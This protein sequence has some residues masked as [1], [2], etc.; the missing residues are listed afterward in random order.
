MIN[1]P[2]AAALAFGLQDEEDREPFLVF[3]VGGGTFDV[4]I[5]E[6]FE[7]VVE[8]RASA[9]DNRL[10]GDDFNEALAAFAKP[11]LDPD[12]RLAA[13]D[14]VKREALLLRAAEAARRL[15]SEADEAVL[16]VV[17]GG[18]ELE[19][20][21]TAADL[22]QACD[23]LIQRLRDPVVRALR[24]CTFEVLELS[25]IVLVGGATRMP[26]VR[27]A[28]TRMFGRFPNTNVHPDHAVALGAAIQAGL[29]PAM[30]RLMKSEFRT[31]ALSPLVSTR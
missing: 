10:G 5:V 21:I 29:L 7:N 12:N 1:E 18:G 14:A 31:S 17:A 2:T 11:R 6:K 3:D 13:L 24:D 25:E 19:T 16:S 28:I 20:R 23:P 15:L 8:V 27:R 4:S 26:I 30:R 22:D 9:G